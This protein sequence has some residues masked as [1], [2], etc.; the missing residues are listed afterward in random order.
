MS[1]HA[2]RALCQFAPWHFVSLA[3][4][5]QGRLIDRILAHFWWILVEPPSPQEFAPLHNQ[6]V[7]RVPRPLKIHASHD[8]YLGFGPLFP[9]GQTSSL[10]HGYRNLLLGKNRCK[11]RSKGGV[12]DSKPF[13]WH[14]S[15][16]ARTND[17]D[18][19]GT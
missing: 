4:F 17:N 19:Y 8:M 9:D 12:T 14:K 3:L 16:T 15:P 1:R 2:T 18:M 5:I 13:P 6:A 11:I 7:G 10:C